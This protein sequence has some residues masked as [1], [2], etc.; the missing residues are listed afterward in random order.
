MEVSACVELFASLAV[1]YVP[2]SHTTSVTRIMFRV[3]MYAR[4]CCLAPFFRLL[5]YG[6]QGFGSATGDAAHRE[7]AHLR[8]SVAT[9]HRRETELDAQVRALQ[10]GL[11]RLAE[12]PDGRQYVTRRHSRAAPLR[13]RR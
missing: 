3:L 12:D 4:L 7:A 2:F 13:A 8:D 1:L 9:L 10:T 6:A 11:R 5:C